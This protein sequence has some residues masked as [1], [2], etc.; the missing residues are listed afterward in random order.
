MRRAL[1]FVLVLAACQ[2]GE[3]ASERTSQ[4][5]VSPSASATV[6]GSSTWRRVADIPT[7]RSEVAAAVFRGVVHLVGGFGGGNVVETYVADRWS[8]A[9]RYPI[10]VDHAMAAGVDT[11]GKP[12]LY[13]FGLC[14]GLG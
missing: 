7:A 12:G 9:A 10:S 3:D 2:P 13:V 1:A 4:S 8:A 5:L 11:D 14:T 6:A